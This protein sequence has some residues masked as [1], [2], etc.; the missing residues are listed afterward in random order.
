[1]FKQNLDG[2]RIKLALGNKAHAVFITPF[3]RKCL[4]RTFCVG[5]GLLIQSVSVY[6]VNETSK[7]R[8][9]FWGE[10]DGKPVRFTMDHV[11]PKR[12]GGSNDPD[13]NIEVLCRYC[14][15]IKGDSLATRPQLWMLKRHMQLREGGKK[16][17]FERIINMGVVLYGPRIYF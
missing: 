6:Q 8:F 7:A 14:N 13:E 10:R 15:L 1:M 12:A 2:F 16:K 4:D 3:A 5:C 11:T 17:M 9:A